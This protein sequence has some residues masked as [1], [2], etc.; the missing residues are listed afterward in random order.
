MKKVLSV[1]LV[2]S[3][4]FGASIAN[5]GGRHH[6]DN[7]GRY[8]GYTAAAAVTVGA[9]TYVANSYYN[10][11]YNSYNRGYNDRARYENARR[12]QEAYD[13]AMRARQYNYYNQPRKVV[14]YEQYPVIQ[15][16]VIYID[17]P[18]YRVSEPI[19]NYSP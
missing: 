16:R 4:I 11:N 17:R 19:Y 14:Y 7:F 1:L 12:E 9:A 3:S 8:L 15:E 10:N 18:V 5:A 13:R 6:H 2:A